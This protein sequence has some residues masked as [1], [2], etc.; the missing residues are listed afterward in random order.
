[1]AERVNADGSRLLYEY[2]DLLRLTR[3]RHADPGPN[4]P[5]LVRELF[6]DQDPDQP[7]AGRFL[8]GRV[9]LARDLGRAV[10]Y[11]YNRAGKPI[12]EETTS[13][14]VTLAVGREYDFQGRL[15]A[16]I[17]P[18]GARYEVTTDDSGSISRMPGVMD[19]VTYDAEGIVTGFTLG[20]GAQ[21]S[22]VHD[23]ASRRLDSLQIAHG[24]NVLRRL[25]YGYDSIGNIISLQ[26]EQP[27]TT[28]H[29]GFDY[30]GLHRLTRF[31]THDGGPGGPLVSQGSYAY[32]DPGNLLTLQEAQALTLS[33]GDAAHPGRLTAVVNGAGSSPVTYNGRGHVTRVGPLGTLEYDPLDRLVRV[34]HA[35][36]TEIRLAYDHQGRRV[37][38]VVTPP[39]GAARTIRYA[40]GVYEQHADHALRHVYFGKRL[41]ATD[42]VAAG[43]ADSRVYYFADHHGTI[44]LSMDAAGTVI[45]QQRYSPFG[46]ALDS[47]VALDRYLGYET[48]GETGLVQLG[49]RMY[50]PAIGRFISPDWYVLEKPDRPA[51]MPQGFNVYGYALNNP[52]VF[53][54]PSGLWFGIDDL[55]VAA[56]GF[57]VGFVS[58]LIYG[59]VN[60]QGWDS[61]LTALETGL[62]TAAGA[63][64]GWNIAGP[65]GAFM[66][67]MNGLVSGIHGIYDWTSVDGWFAFISDSTWNLFGTSLGNV[68]H[69]INLFYGDA[70]YREDLSHRQNRHVYEGGFALKENF[71]FTQGN[72]ISNAG[73]GRGA[74][75]INP[76]F[77][78]DH[79]ELHIWQQRFFGPLFQATYIVWAVGGFFV[80]TVTWF[81][82][83]DESW[84]SLVETAAYYDNPFE[85]WAY[86]NDS[87][88]PP[89][90]ANPKLTY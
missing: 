22:A 6:Y 42:R 60:G 58:G 56:V 83:T 63:W 36:G 13:S 32:D 10:R 34:V 25:A 9:A 82:N 52:L 61:L 50:L 18:D 21:V 4:A 39:G 23:P 27:G 81:F 20:N 62:T 16:V 15:A 76:S 55:I 69:I 44:L 28:T 30:D 59:L 90:G 43:A 35:D 31:E 26:D 38:K 66:G 45:H 8:D 88:W 65:V 64:L 87:N 57:V 73:L 70:N 68:V 80:G 53:K 78:A 11:S 51:R 2:D 48:D 77:I 1:M 41:V 17:Y 72:V 86:K 37:E 67:G 47:A 49:E 79:E 33:Y 74:A 12:R 7:G 89:S 3:L 29:Q 14:G 84:G 5:T 71:A 19:H 40:G 85:Y 75:G 46:L 24:G 54:D